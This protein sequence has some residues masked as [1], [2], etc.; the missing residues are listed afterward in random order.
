MPWPSQLLHKDSLAKVIEVLSN[1]KGKSLSCLA[2]HFEEL[3]TLAYSVSLLQWQR[4]KS[5]RMNRTPRMT[6]HGENLIA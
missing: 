3:R 5:P 4:S 2:M 6:L 1:L